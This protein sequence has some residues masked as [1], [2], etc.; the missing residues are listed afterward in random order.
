MAPAGELLQKHAL[1]TG[2]ATAAI[3]TLRGEKSATS[4][5]RRNRME[6]HH[7]R[8]EETADNAVVVL[9][10]ATLRAAAVVATEEDPTTVGAVVDPCV[11]RHAVAVAVIGSDHIERFRIFCDVRVPFPTLP[12]TIDYPYTIS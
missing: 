9:M 5:N 6:Q 12:L 10:E 7:L 2:I 3:K 11:V 4:A 1:A 8:D